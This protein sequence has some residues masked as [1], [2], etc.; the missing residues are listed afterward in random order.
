M[1]RFSQL[2][3]SLSSPTHTYVMWSKYGKCL[4]PI[5]G[6]ICPRSCL[7]A[8]ASA[9]L[10]CPNLE[11]PAS[12]DQRWRGDHSICR[13]IVSVTLIMWQKYP[14]KPRSFSH[15]FWKMFWH[16]RLPLYRV[17]MNISNHDMAWIAFHV[18]IFMLN[19]CD[20]LWRQIIVQ[21]SYNRR[22]PGTHYVPF[23]SSVVWH[24]SAT[25]KLRWPMI[26]ST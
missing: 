25:R 26:S 6:E 15:I 1:L 13:Q 5:H 21:R 14:I 2:R 24:F 12:D 18:T 9:I 20:L 8:N 7:P 19:F 3:M 22:Y 4:L 16:K 11:I 17:C 10:G 23:W